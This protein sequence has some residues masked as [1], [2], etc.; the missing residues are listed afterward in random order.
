MSS[1]VEL[2]DDE[3]VGQHFFVDTFPLSK[4]FEGKV[5]SSL[6]YIVRVLQHNKYATD[7]YVVHSKVVW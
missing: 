7:E 1:E 4:I 5:E 3:N 2:L 6:I